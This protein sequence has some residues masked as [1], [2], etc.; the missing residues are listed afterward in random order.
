MIG[1]SSAATTNATS[2]NISNINGTSSIISVSSNGGPSNGDSYN[3]FDS[4]SITDN[5][6]YI[7]YLS[8]ATDLITN[9][10]NYP[11]IDSSIYRQVYLRD[12]I[13][14]TTTL[15]SKN[16]T[17]SPANYPCWDTAISGNGNY[18]VYASSATNLIKGINPYENAA[19]YVYNRLT[20]TTTCI[21]LSYSNKN[22]TATGGESN[23]VGSFSMSDN[24]R[25]ISYVSDETNLV[26]NITNIYQN[27]FLYDQ[28][29]GST[30]LINTATNNT[31]A[32]ENSWYPSISSDGQYIVYESAANNLI[33]NDTNGIPD[34]FLYNTQTK[35][36]KRIDTSNNGTQ[37]NGL[38][39]DPVISGNGEYVA[40]YSEALNLVP[41]T[42]SLK[43]CGGNIVGSYD[44]LY[45]VLTGTTSMVDTSP[46]GI[47]LGISD[48]GHYI[49]FV[50][51]ATN[52]DPTANIT[53]NYACVFL[54][55]TINN[56]TKLI[57]GS[58]DNTTGLNEHCLY[59]VIS[60]DGLHIVYTG[61]A[62]YSLPG[63]KPDGYSNVYLYTI[64]TP[65]ILNTNPSNNTV[66]VTTNKT[67]TIN[68]NENI[69]TGNNNIQLKTNNGTNVPF[70]EF[71]NGKTLTITPNTLIND[72]KYILTLNTGSLTDA[73]GYPL[74]LY[75]TSFTTGPPPLILTVNPSNNAVN[76]TTNKTI[77]INFNENIKTGNNNIQLETSNGTNISFTE[78]INGSILT[79]TPKTMLVKDTKY[80]LTLHTGSI[81]DTVGN[82]LTLISTS[83]TTGP[84]PIILTVN[85]SNNAVNVTTNKTI[86]INFNENIK[87]G[88]NNIQ[89]E[90]S[91]GTNI[92]FTESING[93]TLTITPQK[94]LVKDTKY[95]LTLHTGSITDTVGN[96]LTLISTSFTTGK[97]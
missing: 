87:T 64:T 18:I 89:L 84:L 76:V 35:T 50:S 22:T 66:N 62:G 58:T 43:T 57:A 77:T 37:A 15:I 93:K 39:E 85:P 60:G 38:S 8:T 29:K 23:D 48:N 24:G 96:P 86:T 91:N 3:D 70:T 59:P 51:D 52:L 67:I 75:T 20:G 25:Y 73:A 45:N 81:T 17:G 26:K 69:K 10:T 28:Q 54:R 41:N 88:N 53:G 44:Y 95:I 36:T 78:S 74:N 90:T 61:D 4:P 21:T 2:N 68:F 83:F 80:I 49:V 79:I 32:N 72:T 82:P 16:S 12:T 40:Y 6:R 97:T 33:N 7:V 11:G 30:T 63:T 9:L 34:I 56:T 19:A 46:D 27:V 14:N 92:P 31:Q 47:G 55:D 71:I 65:K 94:T 13:T 5:G 1:S 42:V